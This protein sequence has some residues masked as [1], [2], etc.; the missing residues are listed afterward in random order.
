[1][2]SPYCPG[3]ARAGRGRGVARA[4]KCETVMQ[5][6]ALGVDRIRTDNDFKNTP[7]LHI[8]ET[9]GYTRRHDGVQFMKKA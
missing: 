3:G 6:I 7:I 5:A 8:N 1:V 9:M 2:V 4:V